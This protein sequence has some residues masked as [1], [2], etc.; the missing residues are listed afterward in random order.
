M[1]GCTHFFGVMTL[2]LLFLLRIKWLNLDQAH[3]CFLYLILNKNHYYCVFV[4]KKQYA[5]AIY[6]QMQQ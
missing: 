5:N 1:K 4:A 3:A 6:F 2:F